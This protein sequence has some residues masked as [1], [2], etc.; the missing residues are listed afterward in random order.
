MSRYRFTG[1]ARQDLQEIAAYIRKD[2]PEAARRTIHRIREVCKTT[3]VRFPEGGTRREDLAAGLRC[4]S[5]GNYVIYFR[6]R[7]PVEIIRVLHGARDVTP[8][9]FN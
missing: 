3:L 1:P 4:F 2:N 9:L 6:G 5:A 7:N 8:N